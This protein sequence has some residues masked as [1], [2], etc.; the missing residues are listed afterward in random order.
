M[1]RDAKVWIEAVIGEKLGSGTFHEQ[2]KDGVALCKLINKLQP[3]SV[4]KINTSKMAFKMMENIGNFLEGCYS[5]GVPKND[6]FQTVDLFE[7]QNMPQVINGI[8]A[9]GRKAQRKGYQGPVCGGAVKEAT[10]NKREFSQQQLKQGEG[11]I[12][13]QMGTNKGAS[14]SGMTA[15]GQQRQIH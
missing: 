13:L 3:G 10:E 7:E 2:L 14:Q 9:L 4:K 5:Y 12:G 15:Y 1:E 6:V 11:V 8:I